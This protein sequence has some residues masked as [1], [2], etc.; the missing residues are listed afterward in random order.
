MKVITSGTNAT[1]LQ[2][3]KLVKSG[4]DKYI[5]SANKIATTA[6]LKYLKSNT[7]T[8]FTGTLRKSYKRGKNPEQSAIYIQ[9]KV[10]LMKFRIIDQG[11]KGIVPKKAKKLYIPLN[12]R[13]ATAYG[14]RIK[15]LKHG[16]DFVLVNSTKAA[17]ALRLTT[18]AERIAKQRFKER[19]RKISNKKTAI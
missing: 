9:G 18:G 11:R 17:K 8:R 10:Q 1:I 7:P 3:Q 13:G 19:I 15:S 16:R 12:K 14:K 5:K 4:I 6:A 2:T